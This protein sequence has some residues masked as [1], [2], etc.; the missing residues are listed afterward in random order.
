M[1]N[2]AQIDFKTDWTKYYSDRLVNLTI[3]RKYTLKKIL[4]YFSKYAPI[5][6][7]ILEIGGGN[8][9]FYEKIQ[10]KYSNAQYKIMDNNSL[11]IDKFLLQYGLS[12]DHAI[13]QDIL[14]DFSCVQSDIV[15]SVGLIEH[16]TPENT[17]KCIEAHFKATKA[18]G[19]VLITYPTPTWLYR[20]SRKIIE[21]FGAWRFHDERPLRNEEV[22]PVIQEKALLLQH[23]TLWPLILTQEIVVAKKNM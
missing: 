8:S 6:D 7:T 14:E 18:G 11:G 5:A 2:K 22:F 4:S 20:S 9:C 10:E 12:K 1:S 19:I 3:T 16:F 23:E 15:F 17:R 13:K 21:Q